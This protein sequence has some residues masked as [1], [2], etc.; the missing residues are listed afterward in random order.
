MPVPKQKSTT[1]TSD[2]ST[3]EPVSSVVPEPHSFHQHLR[4]QI[5][6][7]VQTVMEEVMRDELTQSSS[8]LLGRMHHRA[9]RLPQWQL[10]ARSVDLIRQD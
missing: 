7:A 4:E 8:S 2:P 9:A 6:L 10:H 1:S 5:R 3:S